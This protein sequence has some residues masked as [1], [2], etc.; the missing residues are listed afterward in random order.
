M[1]DALPQPHGFEGFGEDGTR[2]RLVRSV[3]H[4]ASACRAASIRVWAESRASSGLILTSVGD[5]SSIRSHPRR[6]LRPARCRRSLLWGAHD[7]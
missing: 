5:C 3:A 2:R 7:G 4:S 6:S 1:R